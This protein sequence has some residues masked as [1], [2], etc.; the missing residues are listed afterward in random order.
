MYQ[1]KVRAEAQGGGY[2]DSE[3]LTMKVGCLPQE[4]IRFSDSSEFISVI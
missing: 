2:T 4:N 3:V 1:F